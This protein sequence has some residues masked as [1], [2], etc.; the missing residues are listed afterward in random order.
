MSKPE[1]SFEQWAR[2]ENH[3]AGKRAAESR[4]CPVCG[5]SGALTNRRDENG[6]RICRWAESGRCKEGAHEP[7]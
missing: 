5:R 4:C 7:Q 2:E 6:N 3:A 1:F